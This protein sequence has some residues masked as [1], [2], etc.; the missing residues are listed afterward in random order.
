MKLYT[1]LGVGPFRSSSIKPG[2]WNLRLGSVQAG[3]FPLLI[4]Y[5]VDGSFGSIAAKGKI[6]LLASGDS[7]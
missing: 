6:T 5:Q 3:A 4:H 2:L 1:D 7:V